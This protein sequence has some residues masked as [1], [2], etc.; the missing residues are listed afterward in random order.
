MAILVDK[1]SRIV[2]QGVGDDMERLHTAASR[3]YDARW[4]RYRAA[5]LQAHP[6]CADPFGVHAQPI[7]PATVV[8]HIVAHKGDHAR[9]WDPANHQPLCASCHGRKSATEPGGRA[10]RP[11]AWA[12][13]F[14]GNPTV[15]LPSPVGRAG[16]LRAAALRGV[17]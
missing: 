17:R 7:P 1:H 11:D 10:H 4:R 14:T 13:R 5:Y 16:Q 9:F 12:G 15:P 6:L 8:D 2:V 3:G